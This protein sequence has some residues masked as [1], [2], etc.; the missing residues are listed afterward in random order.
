MDSK[1]CSI[2]IAAT[3]ETDEQGIDLKH[4]VD[5]SLKDVKEKQVSFSIADYPQHRSERP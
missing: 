5:E 1:L 3:I 4:K 2:R